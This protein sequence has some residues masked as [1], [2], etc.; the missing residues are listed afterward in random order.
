MKNILWALFAI[1]NFANAQNIKTIKA[2]VNKATVYLQGATLTCST[3]AHLK[4]GVN[5]I[6][7]T[8]IP[9]DVN[10]QSITATGSGAFTI[11]DATLVLKEKDSIG[12][13]A[14]AA[15]INKAKWLTDSLHLLQSET[16]MLSDNLNTLQLEKTALNNHKLIKGDF[17]SDSLELLKHVLIYMRERLF[18]ITNETYK[19]KNQLKSKTEQI[20]ILQEQINELNQLNNATPTKVTES[21]IQVSIY[22]KAD[23]QGQ[24]GISFY[25]A[26][27]GWRPSYD[28]R[29][30]ST[31]VQID[32]LHKAHIFQQSGLQWNE[33]D[34]TL[35]TAN[36]LNTELMP[37][38]QPV[39]I[40]YFK[41]F[42][43]RENETQKL[44]ATA[45]IP[46]IQD[47]KIL[48]TTFEAFS[49]VVNGMLQTEYVIKTSCTI[50][51]DIK[52]QIVVIQNKQISTNYEV[53]CMPRLSTFGYMQASITNWEQL[54][55][56][57]ATA[58]MYFDDSYLGETFI[59]PNEVN[60]TLKINLGVDKSIIVKRNQRKDK[61]STKMFVDKKVIS[62][63][64]EIVIKNIKPKFVDLIIMDVIP[65]SREKDIEVTLVDNS[66]AAYNSENG[67][68]IWKE[69]LKSNETKKYNVSYEVSLPKQ[70][71]IAL[72]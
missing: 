40:S 53:L 69:R 32:L 20:A 30:S 5:T 9:N 4:A 72:H 7:F 11:V 22:A 60:D 15:S 50:P 46:V 25:V 52:E 70:K 38:L 28:L 67:F 31:N 10:A 47:A 24:I 61:N 62:Y 1:T 13:P 34:L 12:K 36:P 43:K 6:T 39:Y 35:S 54:N 48:D 23:L 8:G 45:D 33:I 37:V 17:K 42:Q 58:K 51:S 63:S 65:V 16:E 2:K 66:D 21:T 41:A 55:L 14:S 71:S 26:N 18:N 68:L 57:P 64:Y 27:A 3:A 44:N 19:I 29:G 49:N 59:N 56:L